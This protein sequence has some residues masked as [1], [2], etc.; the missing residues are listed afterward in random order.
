ME[1]SGFEGQFVRIDVI[2]VEK[3]GIGVATGSKSFMVR[4][5]LGQFG[6]ILSCS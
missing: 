2:L 3:I 1:N 4:G 5:F 6:F